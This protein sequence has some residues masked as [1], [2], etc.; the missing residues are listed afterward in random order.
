MYVT[1]KYSQ[2]HADMH[3]KTVTQ[4]DAVRCSQI[5]QDM[6]CFQKCTCAC[7]HDKK[8]YTYALP[9]SNAY[10]MCLHV[11]WH[12][13]IRHT[14]TYALDTALMSQDICR[15]SQIDADTGKC[16]SHIHCVYVTCIQP[17]SVHMCVHMC[18]VCASHTCTYINP[19]VC[20]MCFTYMHICTDRITDVWELLLVIY[21]L[22][23]PS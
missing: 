9:L 11:C 19:Y 17:Y 15:Y 2:I 8:T 7:I 3:C 13:C 5:H 6:H 18:A 1:S 20:C 21:Y 16:I 10:F 22:E 14:C 23:K 12:V 4:S